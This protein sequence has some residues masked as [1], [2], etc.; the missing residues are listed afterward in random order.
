MVRYNEYELIYLYRDSNEIALSLLFDKYQNLIKKI[1][2]E[3]NI[4]YEIDDAY[5]NAY[6]TL[7]NCIRLYDMDSNV[8]FLS[9][10]L[11]SLKYEMFRAKKKDMTYLN[12]ISYNDDIYIKRN[13]LVLNEP[14]INYEE[15]N[16]YQ[17]I[18]KDVI[19][20]IIIYGMSP[21]VF[22]KNHNMEIKKV[23]NIIYRVKQKL[24]KSI[25]LK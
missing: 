14:E 4:N 13:C 15:I 9:Y 2:F 3:R 11:I 16:K 6:I 5:Q 21:S 20:E 19:D 1:I 23:Y 22:A 18:E 7:Y 24:R 10:L 12:T 25:N 8:P 17:K